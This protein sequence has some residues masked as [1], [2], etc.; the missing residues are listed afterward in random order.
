MWKC[1]YS[2]AMS[3]A[4]VAKKSGAKSLHKHDKTR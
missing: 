3:G 1:F 4:F 2:V